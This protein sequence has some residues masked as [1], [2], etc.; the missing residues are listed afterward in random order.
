MSKK[1]RKCHGYGIWEQINNTLRQERRVKEARHQEP[2]A[3]VVDSHRV[4]TTAKRGRYMA[5]VVVK[6]LNSLKITLK[7]K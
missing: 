2:T 3:A 5:M 7:G 1:F 4:K 6:Q